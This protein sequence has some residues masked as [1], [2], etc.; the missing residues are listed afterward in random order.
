MT[1]RNALWLSRARLR[2]D[3]G[4]AALAP[5]LLP[6]EQ[7][8]RVDAA[9]RLVWSLF[10]DSPERQRDFLWREE[11]PGHFLLLSA[12]R[13]AEDG[14]LFEVESKP[15]AP[16]LGIG[17]RLAFLLRAN[18][19]TA[20]Y[21]QGQRGKPVDVV[22]HALYAVP[23]GQR[24]EQR[25]RSV[26][27]AGMAWLGRQGACCGF[28]PDLATLAVDG[29]DVRIVPRAKGDPIRFA[30]LDIAGVLEVREPAAFLA[31]LAKGFGRAKAFGCGLM[32]IR[33]I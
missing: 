12:R 15:F 14:P 26:R 8:R 30:V 21:Q 17:N 5:L 7:D 27:D 22:M 11:E 33:R 25:A 4:L 1:E 32:L 10:A 20:R 2:R 6:P 18:A 3:A 9:H 29:H 28:A 23:S 19:T 31:A 24:A 16:V 13:P